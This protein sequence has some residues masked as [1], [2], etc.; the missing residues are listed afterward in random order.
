MTLQLFRPPAS[1]PNHCVLLAMTP[2]LLLKMLQ[3][4]QENIITSGILL[5]LVLLSFPIIVE[6]TTLLLEAMC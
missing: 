2:V 6:L 4:E 5:I 3:E 1:L